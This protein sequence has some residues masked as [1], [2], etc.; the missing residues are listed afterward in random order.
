[1]TSARL[2]ALARA[3]NDE[4]VR[5]D[6]REGPARDVARRKQDTDDAQVAREKARLANREKFQP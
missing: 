6:Q 5:I 4:A 3:A 2:D 1:V